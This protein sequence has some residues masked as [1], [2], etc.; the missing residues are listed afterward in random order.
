[1]PILTA[2]W[3]VP[4][5]SFLAKIAT[6][7]MIVILLV[8]V[9]WALLFVLFTAFALDT[10][11]FGNGTQDAGIWGTLLRPLETLVLGWLMI[12]LP[13]KL[14]KLAA[15]SAAMSTLTGGGG[16]GGGG[17]RGG[18]G[19]VG[20]ARRGVGQMAW[21]AARQRF[22]GAMI[23]GDVQYDRDASGNVRLNKNPNLKWGGS[24][25][26][27]GSVKK[28]GILN[29]AEG[30]E[31]SAYSEQVGRV[32][33]GN[34]AKNNEWVRDAESAVAFLDDALKNIKKEGPKRYGRPENGG[35]VGGIPADESHPNWNIGDDPPTVTTEV[36]EVLGQEPQD[37]PTDAPRGGT[38]TPGPAG[39][40]E[41]GEVRDGY[42]V[43]DTFEYDPPA[44]SG[45]D[46]PSRSDGDG[47]PPASGPASDGGGS[48][49]P[50]PSDPVPR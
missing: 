17:S 8:P 49:T 19:A 6:K 29:E 38:D 14:A 37:Q 9:I 11:T 3:P 25:A 26:E 47:P 13:M 35:D 1:M 18:G 32:A 33:K 10:L 44:T 7:V 42:V 36:T 27:D 23:G 16:G 39:G 31:W 41:S 24:S 15:L 4:L 45:D 30:Q 40:A 22:E 12:S 28:D 43:S 34:E 46:A 5:L 20:Q 21:G 48:A 2:F 50:P